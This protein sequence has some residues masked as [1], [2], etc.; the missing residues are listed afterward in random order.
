MAISPYVRRQK[1]ISL[2]HEGNFVE[3]AYLS[4]YFDVSE[5]TIRRDLEKLEEDGEIIR[6]HGGAKL[7]TKSIYEAT[8]EERRIKNILEKQAVARKAAELVE[9]GDVI[10]LDASSTALEVSKQIKGKKKLVVVTNNI[11]V[12]KELSE[13]KDHTIILLG[14]IVRKKSLSL[15]GPYVKNM[16][17][18]IYI[19]KAFISSKALAFKSG[20]TDATID[21]GEVKKAM[22]KNSKNVYIIVDHTKINETA[23]FQVCD[24]R[25]MNKIITDDLG[26]LTKEQENCLQE[27][28]NEGIE[29]VIG[30]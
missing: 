7:N 16:L 4:N 26:V 1:I 25:E 24:Y 2:L 14:G 21:E 28:R 15:I 6:L 5:M 17:S 22:I 27:F 8:L 19:D 29:V 10:A 13:C 3:I 12:A 9:D 11:S 18:S 23:F 20:L 30:S